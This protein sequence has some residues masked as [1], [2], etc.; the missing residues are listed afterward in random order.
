M[1][2]CWWRLWQLLGELRRHLLWQL[3]WH[4]LWHVRMDLLRSSL[5]RLLGM[6]GMRLLTR[7]LCSCSTKSCCSCRRRHLLR[8]RCLLLHAASTLRWCCTWSSSRLWRLHS[9]AKLCWRCRLKR[10]SSHRSSQLPHPARGWLMLGLWHC[11]LRLLLLLLL[12]QLLR[13]MPPFMLNLLWLRLRCDGPGSRDGAI[14][15]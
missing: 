8:R 13:S 12:L 14:N 2:M 7:P 15:A 10:S 4:L 3:L 5:L 1:G 9:T 11:L 6:L